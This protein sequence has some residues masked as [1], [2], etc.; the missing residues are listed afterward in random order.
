MGKFEIG[1]F[2]FSYSKARA[3]FQLE[4]SGKLNYSKPYLVFFFTNDTIENPA[5]TR[6]IPIDFFSSA[7]RSSFSIEVTFDHV[8]SAIYRKCN[9]SLYIWFEWI[10]LNLFWYFTLIHIPNK[11]NHLFIFSINANWKPESSW[12]WNTKDEFWFQKSICIDLM[13]KMCCKNKSW[14]TK[15]CSEFQ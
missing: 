2:R 4:L 7:F 5:F 11:I 15:I 10:I 8:Y 3:W 6:T 14:M 13:L 12:N 1:D 9:K